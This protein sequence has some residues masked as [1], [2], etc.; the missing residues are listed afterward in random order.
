M[1][2]LI[3]E[4][5]ATARRVLEALLARWG[6]EVVAVEDG[7]A[8]WEALRAEDAP[9][10]AILDWMMPKVDGVEVCRRVR[11]M[12]GGEGIYIILLTARSEQEDLVAGLG[13][14]ADDFVTKPFEPEELRA[15]VTVGERVAGLQAALQR[16]VTELEEA[17][18]QIKTL[19]GLLP[20]CSYC[21]KIRDDQ[22]YWQ[23]VETYLAQHSDARFTHGICPECY[24]KHVVPQIEEVRR[25]KQA[26][27]AKKQ[28]DR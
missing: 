10:L 11:R 14:G 19:R 15:R 16:R 28:E 8:A 20:I 1:R 9:R 27:E 13:A 12:A 2:V 5:D 24:Q 7:E 17:L 3:A 21:K 25:R 6:H 26:A 18:D 23:R 22:N 4:D